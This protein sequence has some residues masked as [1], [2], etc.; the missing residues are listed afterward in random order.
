MFSPAQCFVVQIAAR[1]PR[2]P[3]IEEELDALDNI[4]LAEDQWRSKLQV[5]QSRVLGLGE[6][7]SQNFP[8]SVDDNNSLREDCIVVSDAGYPKIPMND[9]TKSGASTLEHVVASILDPKNPNST[10]LAAMDPT[11][12]QLA[13]MYGMM[14]PGY[15][16]MPTSSV[17]PSPRP[18]Y[19]SSPGR[20]SGTPGR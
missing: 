20:T 18:P 11:G 15:P 3:Q 7:K 4:I 2:I 12:Q 14:P 16:G 9:K 1:N 8:L 19:T 5:L 10:S 13:A 6:G 17:Q